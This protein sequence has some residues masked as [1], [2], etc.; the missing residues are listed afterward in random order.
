MLAEL[1]RLA[2]NAHDPAIDRV[3]SDGVRLARVIESILV[4]SAPPGIRT[5][6]SIVNVADL[7]REVAGSE[8]E[9]DAPDEALVEG[10]ER[11]IALALQN[12]LDNARKYSGHNA[13]VVRVTRRAELLRIAVVDDGPGLD[14]AE[15]GKM[16]ERYWR[17]GS[18]PGGTGL[19]LALVRAVAERHGGAAEAIAN[20]E[21]RG[22]EV[23]FTIGP[24]VGW[25]EQRGGG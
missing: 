6:S 25:H 18:E 22:L 15:R 1:E 20:P 13:R 24:V 5:G 16:F 4:L 19:G 3:H 10:D 21:G 17:A 2:A 23:A 7:S 14:A 11:L 8:V 12:L 9:V